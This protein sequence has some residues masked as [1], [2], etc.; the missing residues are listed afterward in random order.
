MNKWTLEGCA[1]AMVQGRPHLARSSRTWPSPAAPQPAAAG[2][3]RP[4]LARVGHTW[5]GLGSAAPTGVAAP[6][7]CHVSGPRHQQ[8]HKHTL[9][10]WDTPVNGRFD[11]KDKVG[12]TWIDGRTLNR[13]NCHQGVILG[14]PQ[15][16]RCITMPLVRVSRTYRAGRTYQLVYRAKPTQGAD[17]QPP[18]E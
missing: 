9:D 12:S 10:G 5:P 1:K 18:Q 11:Q 3:S 2:Q 16:G 13:R 15:H 8:S 4:Q 14:I 17:L 7:I 6:T